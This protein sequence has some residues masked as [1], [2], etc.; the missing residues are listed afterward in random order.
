[1]Q[2]YPL[3]ALD[4]R[5]FTDKLGNMS[6]AVYVNTIVCQ[7]LSYDLKLFHALGNKFPNLGKNFRLRPAHV[8][9]SDNR[10]GAVGTMAVATLADFQVCIML[11]CCQMTLAR[12]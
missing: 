2:S 7:F 12:A 8:L 11:W 9:A 4:I 1:M 6:L 5:H 10:Y 3:H